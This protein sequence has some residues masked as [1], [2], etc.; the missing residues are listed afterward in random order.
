MAY[1]PNYKM[2]LPNGVMITGNAE[3]VLRIVNLAGYE[4]LVDETVWHFSASKNKL[5][6]IKEMETTYLGNAIVKRFGSF[7][8]GSLSYDRRVSLDGI[9]DLSEDKHLWALVNEY[10]SRTQ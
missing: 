10:K 1:Q 7:L 8:N 3:D 9:I 2:L 5:V 6:P 4:A